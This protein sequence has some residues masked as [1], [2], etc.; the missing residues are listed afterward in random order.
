[1]KKNKLKATIFTN[2]NFIIILINSSTKSNQNPSLLKQKMKIVISESQNTNVMQYSTK[3][4][5]NG[6]VWIW[7]IMKKERSKL[8]PWNK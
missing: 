8:E 1:M 6:V 7:F 3:G 4:A 2:N 5:S